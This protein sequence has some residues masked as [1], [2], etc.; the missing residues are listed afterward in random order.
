MYIIIYHFI[1]NNI[2]K[3][4]CSAYFKYNNIKRPLIKCKNIP[5]ETINCIGMPSG[6][7]ETITILAMLLLKE[8]YISLENAILL[9]IIFSLQRILSNMHTFNQVIIG[10]MLGLF[11]S[12]IYNLSSNSFIIILFIGFMLSYLI[13]MKIDSTIK[14]TDIPKWVSAEMYPNITKKQNISKIFKIAH[15]YPNVLIDSPLFLSWNKLEYILDNIIEKIKYFENK[16]SIKFDAII[17]IKMGGAILSD[18]ISNKLKIKNYKIKLKKTACSKSTEN[19][20]TIYNVFSKQITNNK[21]EICENINDNITNYNIFLID[22]NLYTGETFREAIYY[23]NEIKKVNY[24]YK[25]CIFINSKNINNDYNY[26]AT[27][28]KGPVVWPWGYDN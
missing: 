12:F 25:Q 16:N 6:H 13:I 9:I 8:K 5:F 15:I 27:T 21:F 1:H 3:M 26:I 10:I 23:L 7:A 22:E 18:Y 24:I 14:K 28:N 19:D 11:Y 2:E 20:N 4:F 17:G